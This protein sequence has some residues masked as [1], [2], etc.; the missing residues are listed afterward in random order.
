MRV[1]VFGTFDLL[2]AGHENFF[3][4]ARKLGK[5]IVV[6]IARDETVRKIKGTKP[7][8]PEK[9]RAENLAKK[10]WADKV[11]LG[12]L[13]DKYKVIRKFK[14]DVIALGYD[15]FAFTFRLEKFII[16]EKMN[17]RVERL[18][19]YRPEI[20]KSSLIRDSWLSQVKEKIVAP[21]GLLTHN[22]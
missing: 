6:V 21:E 3:E 16:E 13:I 20:Y 19:P 22:R 11:T 12:D 10:N 8:H 14:P 7:T 4:Q 1:M 2:H 18:K 9:K 15:Q 5:E 17:T